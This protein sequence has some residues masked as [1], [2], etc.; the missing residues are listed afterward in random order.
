MDT[1]HFG[2]LTFVTYETGLQILPNREHQGGVDISDVEEAYLDGVDFDRDRMLWDLLDTAL[3]NGWDRF[4]P[5][6]IGALTSCELILSADICREMVYWHE[7][8][9]VEF[10]LDALM[11][12][13]G[14]WL[15]GCQ[16]EELPDNA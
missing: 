10:A 16:L 9:Q 8:Y 14:L 12:S 13:G 11:S 6:E 2:P 1:R 7:R 15:Q 4:S 5:E 3:G